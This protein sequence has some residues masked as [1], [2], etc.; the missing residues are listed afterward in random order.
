MTAV[1]PGVGPGAFNHSE[2][3]EPRGTPAP[4]VEC[5]LGLD[6]GGGSTE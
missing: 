1:P 5:L 3:R 2:K 6:L 4:S